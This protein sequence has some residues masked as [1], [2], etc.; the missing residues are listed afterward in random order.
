MVQVDV[1]V[2]SGVANVPD[3]ADF[4]KWLEKTI[5]QVGT[6]ATREIEISVRIVDEDEGRSLNNRYR[7]KDS[8]TNVLSFPMVDPGCAAPPAGQPLALGDIVICGPVVA[9]EAHEQGRDDAEHWAHMLVHGALHL[10]GYDHETDE[11]A[12]EMET[13]EIRIL[14]EGGIRNPYQ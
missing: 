12:L 8:A 1:Q 9:R 7:G 4:Q 10:C 14:A 5:S 3:V 2:A 11:Q 6:G 13:L